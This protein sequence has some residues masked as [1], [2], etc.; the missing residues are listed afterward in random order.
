M[1]AHPRGTRLKRAF[2][3]CFHCQRSSGKVSG[4]FLPGKSFKILIFRFSRYLQQDYNVHYTSI[5]SLYLYTNAGLLALRSWYPLVPRFQAKQNNFCGDLWTRCFDSDAAN[6]ERRRTVEQY[7]V[8]SFQ[9][10]KLS[11]HDRYRAQPEGALYRSLETRYKVYAS[12][13][14]ERALQ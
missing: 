3:V 2:V 10:S 8:L 11:F 13:E 9:V 6:G 12:G 1:R 5:G 4:E 14:Q 7:N